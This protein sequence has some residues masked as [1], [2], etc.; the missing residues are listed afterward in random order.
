MTTKI[1]I[2]TANA[3]LLGWH[4][5]SDAEIA[6]MRANL[7]AGTADIYDQTYLANLRTVSLSVARRNFRA[8]NRETGER[9]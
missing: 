2:T 3:Q 1:N 8:I 6:E 4:V 5:I 7:A 9:V